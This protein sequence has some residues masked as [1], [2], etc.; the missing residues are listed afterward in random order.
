MFF[1]NAVSGRV[2]KIQENQ[3]SELLQC[4]DEI[5]FEQDTLISGPIRIIRF[6]N[7]YFVQE[8]TDKKQIIV[9]KYGTLNN[10]QSFVDNRLNIYEKRWNGCGCKINYSQ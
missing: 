10:A 3:L 7:K 6:G 4:A 9:R 1:E 8:T 2:Y 5:C